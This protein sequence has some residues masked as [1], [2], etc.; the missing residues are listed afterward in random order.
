MMNIS[1]QLDALINDIQA[2]TNDV[3]LSTAVLIKP[4]KIEVLPEKE[5]TINDLDSLVK[6]FDSMGASAR[7]NVFKSPRQRP[8]E[9]GGLITG[10]VE[11]EELTQILLDLGTFVIKG[12]DLKKIS[13]GDCVYCK[14]T[15][16]V[17]VS[18]TGGMKYHPEHLFCSKCGNATSAGKF[19]EQ[20]N[21]VLCVDCYEGGAPRCAKCQEP[22]VGQAVNAIG[23]RWHPE[24]FVCTI[25]G[26]S[27]S[28]GKYFEK[29]GKPYCD[30]DYKTKFLNCR[31][32][33]QP[34][35]GEAV[36]AL[37]AMWHSEHFS[38]QVCRKPFGQNFFQNE[39]LIYCDKH[40]YELMKIPRCNS[41][42]QPITGKCLSALGKQW[43]PDHFICGLC[44][45]PLGPDYKSQGDKGYCPSCYDNLYTH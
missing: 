3:Q 44:T 20:Q 9:D 35:T 22:I 28:D 34:I 5:Y 32:C 45:T 6:D 39:G 43:H 8:R 15:I 25:C 10:A 21:K 19:Y 17:D 18:E 29:D 38:C 16:L 27:F 33:G 36:T 1:D 40:Y 37:G 30:K 14:K 31:S 13:F 4:Q 12:V 23:R 24:H 41:C 42:A 26:S 2:N 11:G 7:R